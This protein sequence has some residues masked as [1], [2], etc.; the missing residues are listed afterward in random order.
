[1]RSYSAVFAAV[2]HV[3][4]APSGRPVSWA[5][6]GRGGG[7]SLPPYASLNLAGHVGD[8]PA[9]VA[10]NRDAVTSA[11]GANDLAITGSVHGARVGI[12]E[13]GGVIEGC[14]A[15]VTATPRLALMALGA[16]CA[17]VGLVTDTAIAVAHCGWQGLVVDCLGAAVA[18]LDDRGA[19]RVRSAVIGP[20]VCGG[21]YP[22]PEERAEAVSSSPASGPGVV[23]RLAGGQSGIDVAEGVRRRLLGLGLDPGSITRAGG[24]TVEDLSAFSYR[25]DGVTGRHG[26]LLMME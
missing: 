13:T 11:I 22:V 1:M 9:F 7:V 19:G 17:V 21:C 18:A 25:R 4:A 12:V 24:C 16:D 2:G 5:A 14:D 23:V 26:L 6:T 3:P 20:A 10:V 8:D 15:L